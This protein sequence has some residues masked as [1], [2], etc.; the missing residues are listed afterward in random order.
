MK[1]QTHYWFAL[2]CNLSISYFI[3]PLPLI[4]WF[5]CLPWLLLLSLVSL[6]PNIFDT[7]FCRDQKTHMC[8][9]RCRHPFTHSPLVFMVIYLILS[10][11]PVD[12]AGY[13]YFVGFFTL[14]YGSHLLLDIFSQ[15]GIPIVVHPTIFIIEIQVEYIRDW[16]IF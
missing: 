4:I 16:K 13:E 11:N 3:S 8:T 2:A 5:F 14:S 10:I 7:W 1:N 9:E 6:I 15:E 12:I